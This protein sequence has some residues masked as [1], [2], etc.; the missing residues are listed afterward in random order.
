MDSALNSAGTP[1]P[2]LHGPAP[3]KPGATKNEQRRYH[4]IGSPLL[5]VWTRLELAT[6]CVTGRHSNQL[7]YHTVLLFAGAKIILFRQSTNSHHIFFD[8][9]Q[10]ED[11]CCST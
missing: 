5:A 8:F 7:N 11:N 9:L 3:Q 6:S 1:F 4:V 2:A 10:P